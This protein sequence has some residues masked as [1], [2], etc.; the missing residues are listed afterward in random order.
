M[1][2]AAMMVQRSANSVIVG[3]SG[4]VYHRCALQESF[5]T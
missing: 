5:F 4:K 1:P 2:S 3:A